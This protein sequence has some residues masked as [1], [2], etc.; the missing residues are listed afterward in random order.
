MLQ[1]WTNIRSQKTL[2]DEGIR[3]EYFY[4]ITESAASFNIT[5]QPPKYI[6]ANTKFD[7]I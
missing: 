2:W 3:V 5:K 4:K 1:V 6:T 7:I